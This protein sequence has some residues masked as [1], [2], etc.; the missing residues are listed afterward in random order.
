MSTSD[1]E[2]DQSCLF[3]Y[4]VKVEGLLKT[5]QKLMIGVL[6]FDGTTQE[7]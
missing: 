5:N 3:F 6:G 2:D 7:I 4:L 1:V